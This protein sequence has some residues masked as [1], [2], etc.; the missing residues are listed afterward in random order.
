MEFATLQRQ[1][2]NKMAKYNVHLYAVVRVDISN[3]EAESQQAAI[4]KAEEETDLHTLL[5]ALEAVEYGEE[6]IGYLV[7]E[8]GDDEFRKSRNY[9]ADGKRQRGN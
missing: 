8:V 2:E 1:E 6:I 5:D 9:N 7:D 3:I 4:R